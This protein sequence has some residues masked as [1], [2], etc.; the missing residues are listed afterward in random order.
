[1]EYPNYSKK[2]GEEKPHDFEKFAPNSSPKKHEHRDNSSL[3]T[4]QI[5]KQRD[6]RKIR[7]N[8]CY[9]SLPLEHA[10]R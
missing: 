5:N 8:Y 6:I 4:S 3:G 7:N 2:E 9:S 1:M 10:L